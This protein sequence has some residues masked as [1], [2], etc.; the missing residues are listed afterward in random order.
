MDGVC[1]K[2]RTSSK[3]EERHFIKI[4]KTHCIDNSIMMIIIYAPDPIQPSPSPPIHSHRL[5]PHPSLPAYKE[6]RPKTKRHSP[7]LNLARSFVD[8]VSFRFP[9]CLPNLHT[10][11]RFTTPQL[12]YYTTTVATRCFECVALSCPIVIK[13][14]GLGR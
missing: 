13:E 5:D 9:P 14:N 10:S 11:L 1:I 3:F 8:F 6:H 4:A 12:P 2:M 7:K